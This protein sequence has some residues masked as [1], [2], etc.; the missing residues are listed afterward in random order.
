MRSNYPTSGPQLTTPPD[1][2]TQGDPPTRR[3]P[4]DPTSA[5]PSFPLEVPWGSF[6]LVHLLR[7]IRTFY[8]RNLKK[9]NV[10]LHPNGCTATNLYV[11]SRTRRNFFS[12]L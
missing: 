9:E 5:G 7:T 6:W 11:Q 4:D 2:I 1:V 8:F 3:D 10:F 12:D